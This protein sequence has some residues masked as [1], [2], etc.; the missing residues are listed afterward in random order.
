MPRA[1]TV[2]YVYVVVLL[3]LLSGLVPALFAQDSTCP[4]IAIAGLDA[5][6]QARSRCRRRRSRSAGSLTYTTPI[7]G[8]I[9]VYAGPGRGFPILNMLASGALMAVNSVT[10]TGRISG[11]MD[12]AL[13]GGQRPWVSSEDARL[14]GG[15]CDLVRVE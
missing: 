3:C 4:V 15:D 8:D 9:N 2:L 14:A 11:G 12:P 1:N 5:S 6:S 10:T 13:A 7:A